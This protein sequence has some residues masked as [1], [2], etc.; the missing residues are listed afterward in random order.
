MERC[1][2]MT[3]LVGTPMTMANLVDRA[4][5]LVADGQRR[6]LGIT[7]A[8][9][10]GKS[11]VAEELVRLLGPAEAVLV[12]QDG[13]HLAQ[14]VLEDLGRTDRK[15][16]FDTFDV[17]GYA[18]ILRDIRVQR[19]MPTV[20]GQVPIIYAPEFRREIEEPIGSAIPV[21]ADVP[22]VVTEGNY[23][24]LD[25]GSWPRATAQIDE[26][27]LLAPPTQTRIERLVAR[28]RRFGRSA[29]EAKERTLGSDQVNAEMIE[30]TAAR[31]D[32]VITLVDG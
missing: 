15:G 2:L 6:I 28:H 11:T 4:R 1:S 20:D 30:A 32:L 25:R 12:G 22:L 9:G 29:E 8:P 10:A 21:S 5:A 16:A 23:L 17:V 13:Y 26:V 31:A 7:G 3:E 27:W 14:R 24:L 18:A 19:T